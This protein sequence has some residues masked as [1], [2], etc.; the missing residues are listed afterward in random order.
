MLVMTGILSEDDTI[1]T[2]AFFR[3][4]VGF[5]LDEFFKRNTDAMRKRCQKVLEALLTPT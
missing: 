2:Y 3:K 4:I 5:E 1:S